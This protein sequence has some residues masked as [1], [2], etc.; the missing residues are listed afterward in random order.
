MA[1]PFHRPEIYKSGYR[2]EVKGF[3]ITVV[4][5]LGAGFLSLYLLFVGLMEMDIVSILVN[6][7]LYAIAMVHYVGAMWHLKNKGIEPDKIF[8][9]VPPA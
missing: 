7:I 5:S 9:I 4:I 6:V 8:S 2:W 1:L 3:P